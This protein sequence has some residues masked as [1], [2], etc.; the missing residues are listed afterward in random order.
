MSALLS[1]AR[2]VLLAVHLATKSNID[3]LT[4]LAAQHSKVLHKELL[5]RILLT[6]LP[7][8]LPSSEYVSLVERIGSGEEEEELVTE[9]EPQE[10]PQEIDWSSVRDFTEE[11]AAKKVR[12]L[13]LLRLAWKDA[14]QEALEDPV[15]LFLIHRAHR[16]D[17]EAGLL[18]QLPDLV[19]PFLHHAPCIR[20][21]V[22]S[23]LLPLLRRNY[24]YY[25]RSPIPQTLAAF[26]RLDDRTAVSLLLSQ[27][28]IREEEL[29]LV[30]RDLRGLVG[31][32]IYNEARW[33]RV[34]VKGDQETGNGKAADQLLCPG[35]E[36]VLEWL[37]AQA[38]R[39]WRVAVK[40]VEQWDG[41]SDVDWAEYGSMWLG[42]EEEGY[43]ERRYA[44]AVLATAYLIPESSIEALNGVNSI[45]TKVANL[46]DQDP[47]PTLQ[48][49]SSLLPPFAEESA[50]GGHLL[51]A[52]NTTY[53]RNELLEDSNPLTT[54]NEMTTRLLHTL[55]LSA[56]ILTKGGA[57]CTIR[58][59]GELAFLQDEREQKAE[60]MKFII[61][62]GNKGPKSDDKYWI[63]AR[64]ELLWLRD[65]GAEEG[66]GENDQK[67][68]GVFGQLNKEF[69]EV[70]CLKAFLSNT[71]KF[72][73]TSL[74]LRSY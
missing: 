49:A 35:W 40:A 65:W 11:E 29:E 2:V 23:A 53:M 67:P 26:E 24:E 21:W 30:G 69:L 59:A 54:P 55:T 8:T 43:L 58:R 4:A 10:P 15:T 70:E 3:A 66:W 63:R 37:I 5:L 60:A 61:A 73:Q 62:L 41:P 25:P 45:I 9:D 17:E 33:S 32:W 39:S 38:S 50:D 71:R 48:V 74:L 14:P 64:N 68:Q 6:C 56:F 22:L 18:T 44:R 27:T 42:D 47:C 13:R 51:C 72:T 12:R 52:K 1:P 31:P 36:Q 16:V 46:L 34:R 28:G 7:E 20:T 57:P 19:V